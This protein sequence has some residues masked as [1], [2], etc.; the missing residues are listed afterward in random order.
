MLKIIL[1]STIGKWRLYEERV[2][3][4]QIDI[5]LIRAIIIKIS[6]QHFFTEKFFEKKLEYQENSNTKRNLLEKDFLADFLDEIL[7]MTKSIDEVF[8]IFPANF[9]AFRELKLPFA[10]HEKINK[11]LLFE[12]EPY[13]AFPVK[14]ISVDFLITKQVEGHPEQTSVLATIIR[15]ADF[16]KLTYAL[17]QVNLSCNKLIPDVLVIYEILKL[18]PEYY[19]SKENIVFIDLREHSCTVGFLLEQRIC[20]I[21]VFNL[22]T[23]E[24]TKN[25]IKATNMSQ[26]NFDLFLQNKKDFFETK[27]KN[28]EDAFNSL[29]ENFNEMFL[30]LESFLLSHTVSG[31]IDKLILFN[32]KTSLETFL[33]KFLEK[34]CNTKVEQIDINTFLQ[35]AK[36]F[37]PE[38]KLTTSSSFIK[39]MTPI[40]ANDLKIF[41]LG[42]K[43]FSDADRSILSKQIIICCLMMTIIFLFIAS[44]GFI[45]INNLSSILTKKEELLAQKLKTLLPKES[46]NSK[47]IVI[48]KMMQ[49]SIKFLEQK[50]SAQNLS[51][52][53]YPN[54]LVTFLELTR[55]FD[56]TRFGVTISSLDFKKDSD[57]EFK[58]TIQGIFDKSKSISDVDNFAAFLRVLNI[59][60]YFVLLQ[61]PENSDVDSETQINFSIILGIRK[62]ENIK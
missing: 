22:G 47:K 46:S 62:N 5:G 30:Y 33:I 18:M 10:E 41:N 42:N 53:D 50:R 17:K 56:R 27:D 52:Y 57:N 60:R 45:K 20:G 23:E 61:S 36:I 4:I 2:L 8:V 49:D 25:T 19:L 44:S 37:V 48:K 55:L 26:E 34:L 21:R 29:K 38:G 6:S 12:L 58:L 24:I 11:V 43:I 39:L 9:T 1:P 51:G 16:A 28:E 54:F 35:N 3:V 40:A 13:L 31:S 32:T 59:S 7:K 14:D 15:D